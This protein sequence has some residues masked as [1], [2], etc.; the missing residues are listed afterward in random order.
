MY[1]KSDDFLSCPP[2]QN[3]KAKKKKKEKENQRILSIH[4]VCKIT[5]CFVIIRYNI[6]AEGKGRLHHLLKPI[7]PSNFLQALQRY[8]GVEA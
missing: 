7:T 1:N 2:T 4:F 3:A 5:F 6:L 8:N